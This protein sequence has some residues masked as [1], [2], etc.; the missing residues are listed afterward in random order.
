MTRVIVKRRVDATE[1]PIFSKMLRFV[2]PLMLANLATQLYNMADNIVVGQFSGDPL[3]LAAV[4]STSAYSSLFLNL[5]L[6]VAGGAGVIVARNFGARNNEGLSR[7]VHTAITLSLIMGVAFGI[8]RFACAEWLLGLMGTKEELMSNALLYNTILSAGMPATVLYAYAAAVLR[9]VGDSK[10][11][12]WAVSSTGIL[13]VVLNLFFVIVCDM[14]V[15]GVALA[16]I[17]AK[18]ISAAIVMLALMRRK[19]EPYAFSIK[20]LGIDRKMVKE[21]LKIGI[22][23]AIQSSLFSFTN[24]FL[25]T[26][27]NTFP[28]EVM[29]ARTIATNIDVLLSTAINTYLHASMTFTSQNYGAKKPE[30][31]K[32]SIL[33][34]LLQAGVIGFVVGQIMLIFHEPLVNMYLAADDPNRALV[35]DY[36]WQI[37]S[38]MLSS[39][40]IGAMMEA[41]SGFL[42]GLGYSI[43]S[44]VVCIMG[45]CLFRSLWIFLVFPKIGSLT[46][47]YLVYPISFTLTSL[48]LGAMAV[49]AFLKVKKK[50]REQALEDEEAQA[51]KE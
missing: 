45:V 43:Y 40:F 41:L 46:S 29:S 1:G 10:T 3:A 30:R 15:A 5:A 16:T 22:P 12:L 42:R 39:Y 19:D 31:M 2:I 4:G 38:V 36:A 18:V 7:S 23:T 28:T 6:G 48:G 17:I 14:S 9:S 26:A 27:L 44:M 33:Y 32:K 24:I 47:L 13:N 21:M 51:N 35:L 20:K 50:F 11:P 25:T 37:M 49:F 8:L 34:A